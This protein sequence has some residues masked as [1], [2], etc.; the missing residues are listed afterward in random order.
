[1]INAWGEKRIFKKGEEAFNAAVV[2]LGALGVISEVTIQV[3]NAFN[4]HDKTFTEK[5]ETVIDK[6]DEYVHGCDHFKLLWLPPSDDVVVYTYRRTQEKT[7]DS[8][9]RQIIND[10]IISVLGYRLLV[11]IGNL[12]RPWRAPINKFLTQNFDNPLDRIEKSYKVFNV[13]EPATQRN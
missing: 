1:M 11:K 5:F 10:E 8:R 3:T 6:I 4:L 7:N 13:P 2:N 12:H 9:F